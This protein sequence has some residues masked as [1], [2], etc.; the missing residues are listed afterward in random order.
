VQPIPVEPSACRPWSGQPVHPGRGGAV[1]PARNQPFDGSSCWKKISPDS[2]VAAAR[3]QSTRPRTWAP[4][5]GRRQ[6]PRGTGVGV[7]PLDAPLLFPSGGFEGRQVAVD[8]VAVIPVVT[9][10]ARSD[11]I[12]ETGVRSSAPTM[13]PPRDPLCDRPFAGLWPGAGRRRP[14]LRR[15][16]RERCDELARIPLAGQSKA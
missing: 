13:P 14:W 7:L 6:R 10:P 16:T 12:K 8:R 4:A 11:E 15:L 3:R 9:W 5:C 1:R 2:A